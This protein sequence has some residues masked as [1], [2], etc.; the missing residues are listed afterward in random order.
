[1]LLLKGVWK[2]GFIVID[3]KDRLVRLEECKIDKIPRA[4]SLGSKQNNK[5]KSLNLFCYE[6]LLFKQVLFKQ[7]CFTF[8]G[9]QRVNKFLSFESLKNICK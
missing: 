7:V 6:E 3:L 2:D 9:M 5:K 8:M 1:M 4:L